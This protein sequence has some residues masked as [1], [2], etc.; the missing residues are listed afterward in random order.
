MS[1]TSSST[2]RSMIRSRIGRIVVLALPLLLPSD[3]WAGDQDPPQAPPAS[4]LLP[5]AEDGFVDSGGVKIHFVSLGSK[6]NPLLI[7]IHGFPDFWY[8]WRA[9]MPAL[10]KSF[11]VVAIDQRG[12]NASGQPEGVPSYTTD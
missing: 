7:L 3:A 8:S 4:S 5:G 11:H 12:Y 9:Q 6:E 2:V 1:M 10:A